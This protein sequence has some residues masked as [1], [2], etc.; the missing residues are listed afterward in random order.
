ME[1]DRGCVRMQD[2]WQTQGSPSPATEHTHKVTVYQS[3]TTIFHYPVSLLFIIQ[4]TGPRK[5][6]VLFCV[7]TAI[8]LIVIIAI[9]LIVI[10]AIYIYI[11]TYEPTVAQE[12]AGRDLLQLSAS[13]SKV[14]R[15][16]I[17]YTIIY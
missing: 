6:T 17:S 16:V 1:T 10:I 8:L 2:E 14:S 9:I 11:Y 4:Y 3:R 5:P 15:I 13:Y 12:E 7:I